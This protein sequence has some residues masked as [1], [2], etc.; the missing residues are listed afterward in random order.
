MWYRAC[1]TWVWQPLMSNQ[2]IAPY[3][4]WQPRAADKGLELHALSEDWLS[5]VQ[6]KDQGSK[7]QK[8]QR[9]HTLVCTVT[10]QWMASVKHQ[11]ENNLPFAAMQITYTNLP[12]VNKGMKIWWFAQIVVSYNIWQ[13]FKKEGYYMWTVKR[14]EKIGCVISTN[15]CK[16]ISNHWYSAESLEYV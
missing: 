14:E 8:S 3:K 9:C 12:T 2:A 7:D 6:E 10:P 1:A 16:K 5:L 4:L 13:I 15:G 11:G